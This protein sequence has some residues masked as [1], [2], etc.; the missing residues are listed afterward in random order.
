MSAG[1]G[2]AFAA[3]A[4]LIVEAV[5]PQQTGEATGIN[6][7]MR[8][9]GAV[10]RLAGL[11]RDPRRHASLAGGPARPRRLHRRVPGLRRRRGARGPDRGRSSRAASTA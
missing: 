11:G 6:T 4:N 8:S 2:L 7:L 3:M 5:P 10:A 9:V 1:I